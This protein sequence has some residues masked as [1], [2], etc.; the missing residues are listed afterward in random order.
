MGRLCKGRHER[1]QSVKVRHGTYASGGG[2]S[3]PVT[4]IKLGLKPEE[5]EDVS[6][7]LKFGLSLVS[8]LNSCKIF[9]AKRYALCDTEFHI[10]S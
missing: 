5:E 2:R 1:E 8:Y 9:V 6:W 10:N 4:P 7:M 3:A